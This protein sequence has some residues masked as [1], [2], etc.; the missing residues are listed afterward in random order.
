MIDTQTRVQEHYNKVKEI[1]INYLS[2]QSLQI[3]KKVEELLNDVLIKLLKY[4]FINN[5]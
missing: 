3:N 5:F 2:T 1:K 4:S